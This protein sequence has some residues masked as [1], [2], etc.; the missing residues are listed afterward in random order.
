MEKIKIPQSQTATRHKK[1]DIETALAW[2]SVKKILS[3]C[4]RSDLFSYIKSVKVTEQYITL[5][6]EK[7]LINEELR[8]V[9]EKEAYPKINTT[10][11]KKIR[12]Q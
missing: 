1:H 4:G 6:T 12:L 11:S 3:E 7:P 8:S 5:R 2:N 9:F 10:T